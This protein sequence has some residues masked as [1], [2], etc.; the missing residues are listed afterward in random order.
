MPYILFFLGTGSEQR[1]K[2]PGFSVNFVR[3]P[4]PKDIRICS[5]YTFLGNF[6]TCILIGL[7]RTIEKGVYGSG[8]ELLAGR[9]VGDAT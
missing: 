8:K 9:S 5:G 4:L 3:V 1:E 6:I 7:G 2:F